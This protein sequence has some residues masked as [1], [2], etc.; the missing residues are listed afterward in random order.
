LSAL[1]QAQDDNFAALRERLRPECERLI[2]QYPDRRSALLPIMHLF[3]AEEGFA[4]QDAMRACAQMLDLTP[5]TVE[6]VVSFYT[7]FFQKPVGKYMLHVCRN[8]SCTLNG[9]QE[10]MA[11]VRDRLGIGH[12]QTT[13]DG[14]FSYEEVECLA[15]CDRAPCMQVNL[16]FVYDLTPQKLDDMLAAMRAGT[17]SVGPLSQTKQPE[18]TWI[19]SEDQEIARGERSPGGVGVEDPD[20]AGGIGDPSGIIM[21]DRILSDPARFAGRTSER[22]VQEP[23]AI[24]EAIQ[25]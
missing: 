17:Y 7:L 14:M 22:V 20:D 11:H 12:L 13:G 23:G 19:P 18:R 25:E 8:L 2:A 6:A 21:L 24:L 10:I 5:A 1:Q 3:V 4:S 9:A 16:E 15:A